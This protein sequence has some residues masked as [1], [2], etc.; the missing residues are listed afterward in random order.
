LFECELRVRAAYDERGNG[1]C[2]H[3]F[4][5]HKIPLLRKL[6]SVETSIHPDH[7]LLRLENPSRAKR[8]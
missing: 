4:L 6:N 7:G 3:K 8:L 5:N 2:R 1:R